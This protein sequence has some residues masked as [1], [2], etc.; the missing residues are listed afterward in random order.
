[1]S[2]WLDC[3]ADQ[4][5]KV[6]Q[7]P[8]GQPSP[9]E[10]E[11]IQLDDHGAVALVITL[12][13]PEQLNP[14][15]WATI[16]SLD[17]A[18]EQADADPLIR[19]VLITGRGRAFCAGGDLKSYETLQKDPIAFP[20]FLQDFHRTTADIK[21]LRKPVVAL[22]NGIVAAGGLELLVSC[23]FTIAAQSA[24]IGD[25]HLQYGQMGGGGIL[26]MLPRMIGPARAR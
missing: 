19:I 23:D 4:M 17:Q 21:F 24:T 5:A 1:M 14:L 9:L 25:A 2:W 7:V 26:T 13:R 8:A 15:D 16:R 18:L 3:K 20:E 6:V 10:T 22:V 11:A 12:N